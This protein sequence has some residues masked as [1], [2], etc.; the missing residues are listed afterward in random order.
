ML[1]TFALME[2]QNCEFLVLPTPMEILLAQIYG[3]AFLLI[4]LVSAITGFGRIYEGENG[5][6]VKARIYE[7]GNQESF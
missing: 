5:E 7:S 3:W 2:M 6:P 4:L 1:P